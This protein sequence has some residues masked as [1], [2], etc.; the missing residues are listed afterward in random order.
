MENKIIADT[1][2]K[3]SDLEAKIEEAKDGDM[4]TMIQMNEM[5]SKI[6]RYVRCSSSNQ[7][8]SILGCEKKS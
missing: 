4:G 8:T 5:V 3:L 7:G 1:Q 6:T 2:Q